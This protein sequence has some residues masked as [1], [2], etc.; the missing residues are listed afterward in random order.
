MLILQFGGL[1]AYTVPYA[2]DYIV[3]A[4]LKKALGNRLCN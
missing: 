2:D 3:P 1:E 4:I